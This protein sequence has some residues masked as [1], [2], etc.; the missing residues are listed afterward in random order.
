MRDLCTIILTA[1]LVG[2]ISSGPQVGD[3]LADFK[4]EG[5]SG[6]DAG[7]ELKFLARSKGEPTLLVFVQKLTRPGFRLLR[8]IDTFAASQDRLKSSIVWVDEKE[9]AEEYLKRAKNSLNFQSPVLIALDGKDGPPTYGLNDQAALTILVARDNRVV[10][11]FALSDP[12]ETDA[13]KVIAAVKK[14]LEK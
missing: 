11:N 9:K 4:A 13:R 2:S 8:A 12:N 6:P 10:A 14:A 5:F 7:K 1:L 3:K